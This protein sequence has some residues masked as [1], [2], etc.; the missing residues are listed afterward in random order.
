TAAD[1]AIAANAAIGVME[2]TGSGIGGDLFVLYYDANSGATYGLN[3]SG[4]TPAKATAKALRSAGNTTMPERGITTVTTPGVVAGW[5]ALHQRFGALPFSELLA[6]AIFYAREGFPVSE[7]IAGNW[8]ASEAVL[9]EHRNS[10]HTFLIDGRA[11]EP[12]Q[13]FHNPDLAVS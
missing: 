10:A 9:S 4:W 8:T 12:G 5:A 3:S 2:P 7:V 11:P 13:I 1:A 6:P